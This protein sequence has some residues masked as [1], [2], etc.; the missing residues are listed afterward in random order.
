VQSCGNIAIVKNYKV[1]YAA[2]LNS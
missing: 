2:P 1:L